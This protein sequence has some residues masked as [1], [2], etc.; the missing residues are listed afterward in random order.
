[1]PGTATQKSNVVTTDTVDD[2][3]PGDRRVPFEAPKRP[4][5]A[6]PHLRW[7]KGRRRRRLGYRRRAA[8]VGRRAVR[9]VAALDPLIRQKTICGT[10]AAGSK[11]SLPDPRGPALRPSLPRVVEQR[12]RLI[13]APQPAPPH[14]SQVGS[15]MIAAV[16]ERVGAGLQVQG[17]P[18]HG[19]DR[20]SQVAAG[21]SH[22]SHGSRVL[23]VE[24]ALPTP[25]D[26]ICT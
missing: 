12:T 13:A 21:S 6:P 16:V 26:S 1:M 22:A 20:H 8:I 25:L 5:P 4:R 18:S 2:E 14:R 7:R 15:G 24:V 19:S 23:R 9:P 11:R 17:H 3:V 10:G